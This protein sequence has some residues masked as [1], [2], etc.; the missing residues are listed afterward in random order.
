MAMNMYK[1]MVNRRLMQSGLCIHAGPPQ[2]EE[3]GA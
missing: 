1:F 3:P 2:R